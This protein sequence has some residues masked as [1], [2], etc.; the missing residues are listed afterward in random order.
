MAQALELYRALDA[1]GVPARLIVAPREGH[2][3]SELRH[4]LRKA[5]EELEWF[6]RYVMGREYVWE[7]APGAKR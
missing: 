6:E 3:W 5:N 1:N 2:Q 4:Q 7:A